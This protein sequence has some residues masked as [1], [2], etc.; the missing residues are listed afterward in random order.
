M[1]LR[2][3]LQL[4]KLRTEC[5]V[6]SWLWFSGRNNALRGT[7]SGPAPQFTEETEARERNGGIQGPQHDGGP[8]GEFWAPLAC[9]PRSPM[10]PH[11]DRVKEGCSSERQFH[12]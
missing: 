11:K 3:S 2:G 6:G 7:W 12:L 1:K 9:I 8:S 10:V 5:W 4:L